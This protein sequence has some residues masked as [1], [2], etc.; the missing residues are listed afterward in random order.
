MKRQIRKTDLAQCSNM[1]CR[2]KCLRKN[3]EGHNRF[4]PGY[5]DK[6]GKYFCEHQIY[7]MQ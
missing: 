1:D 2:L 4:E 7:K 5:D 6:T 3:P